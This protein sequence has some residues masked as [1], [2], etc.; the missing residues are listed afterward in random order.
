MLLSRWCHIFNIT[1]DLQLYNANLISIH[2]LSDKHNVYWFITG[3]WRPENF[4]VLSNYGEKIMNINLDNTIKISIADT[5]CIERLNI[6]YVRNSIPQNYVCRNY[7]IPHSMP[8]GREKNPQ[9]KAKDRMETGS[10]MSDDAT[11]CINKISPLS[12]TSASKSSQTDYFGETPLPKVCSK[13]D[14]NEFSISR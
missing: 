6:R 10:N 4:I 11:P 5:A 8:E 7:S 9:K 2:I 3:D 1:I 13:E 14:N 12:P